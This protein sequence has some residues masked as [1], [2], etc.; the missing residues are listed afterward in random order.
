MR[1]LVVSQSYL[2]DDP[3]DIAGVFIHRQFLALKARGWDVRVITGQAL[4]HRSFKRTN[5]YYPH[6]SQRDGIP[7]WRPRY[8]WIPRL[9]VNA[10]IRLESA[11]A[12]AVFSVIEEVTHDWLPDLIIAD[13]LVPGGLAVAKLAHR[14]QAP[15]ILRARGHDVPILVQYSQISKKHQQHYCQIM[16]RA[17]R[18][19]CQGE[20]LYEE[21]KQS[22]FFTHLFEQ[23]KV[24]AITNGVDTSLF[25][26]TDPDEQ[27]ASRHA[28]NIPSEAQVWCYA[29]RWEQ[30]KGSR[31]LLHSLRNL[32][33]QFPNLYF[34][35]AGPIRDT[36]T[37]EELQQVSDRVRF[38]GSQ[39][40]ADMGKLFRAS[41][42][43]VLPTYHEGLPNSV[44]ETMACGLI[45]VTTPV[46]GIPAVIQHGVNGLLVE[47]QNATA[48][49]KTLANC[50]QNLAV[51]RG[52]GSA[53]R[54]TIFEGGY[55]LESVA[56]QLDGL[57]LSII[58]PKIP[59]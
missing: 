4:F 30:D 19:I 50:A 44:I 58:G 28:L 31:E 6:V 7:I 41:D 22:N 51:Y 40:P 37:Y 54:R 3:T 10:G 12:A 27:I 35:A 52:L 26:P 34:I 36:Q 43:F 47:P 24:L 49:E 2:S 45:V 5:R 1:L 32:L 55:D 16:D 20:G 18:I 11:Y 23:E 9:L 46:G 42:I 8:F 59:L 38:L 53:A 13:W 17:A 29:G 15:Y 33:P 21:L 39:K 48:L 56:R 57:F 14:F 25:Y